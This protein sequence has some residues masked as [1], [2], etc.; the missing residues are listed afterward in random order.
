MTTSLQ[1]RLDYI[2]KKVAFAT[3]ERPQV[4][5]LVTGY[6]VGISEKA[7]SL[8]REAQTMGEVSETSSASKKV[9]RVLVEIVN[10]SL[11]TMH[12]LDVIPPDNDELSVFLDGLPDE[13]MHDK[14]LATLL[15]IRSASDALLEY[16]IEQEQ[17]SDDFCDCLADLICGAICFAELLGYDASDLLTGPL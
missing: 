5:D 2:S 7:N 6:L 12:V 15:I 9:L 8:L 11:L 4:S 10:L 1:E 16:Y 17:V 3:E 13:I 14:V